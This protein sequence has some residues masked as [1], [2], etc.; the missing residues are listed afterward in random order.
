[1]AAEHG[2]NHR[3]AAVE[4]TKRR[5]L[6]EVRQ[7]IEAEPLPVTEIALRLFRKRLSGSA[8]H[9]AMAEV[10]AFLAYYDVRGLAQ[11]VRGSDGVFRWYPVHRP[12]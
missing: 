9:F 12:S 1:M 10:L 5:R 11:R 3:A 7:I 8:Q 6:E 2:L 4:R